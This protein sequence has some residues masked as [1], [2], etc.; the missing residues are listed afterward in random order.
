MARIQIAPIQNLINIGSN[1]KFINNRELDPKVG[2][3]MINRAQFVNNIIKR[4]TKK[5]T[6]LG[7]IQNVSNSENW[8][9]NKVKIEIDIENG[10]FKS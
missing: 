2:S 8:Q 5:M 7:I 1:V 3:I 10:R 9:I 6:Y 4:I